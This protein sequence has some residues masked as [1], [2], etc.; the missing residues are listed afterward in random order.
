MLDG[1]KTIIESQGEKIKS[2]E[3]E[4]REV[5]EELLTRTEDLE[6]YRNEYD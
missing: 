2:L 3:A 1:Q 6:Y 5:K 4:M